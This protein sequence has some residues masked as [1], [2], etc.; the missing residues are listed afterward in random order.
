M[1]VIKAIQ[2]LNKLLDAINLVV[3]RKSRRAGR[4]S[5][6]LRFVALRTGR[7]LLFFSLSVLIPRFFMRISRRKPQA[8]IP[9]RPADFLKEHGGKIERVTAR[10][11]NDAHV[12]SLMQENL[13]GVVSLGE[14][15]GHPT[16]Q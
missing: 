5:V 9:R 15:T 3:P 2:D 13:D 8:D 12:S 6:S 1:W 10:R 11:A 4:R 7:F 16:H 14:Q